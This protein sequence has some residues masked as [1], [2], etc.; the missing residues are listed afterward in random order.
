MN[1]SEPDLPTDADGGH[2]PLV[3]PRHATPLSEL[4]GDSPP[5]VRVRETIQ[6]LMSR[7]A[8]ARRLSPILLEGE[9]GTGKGLLAS[10][11]HRLT[12]RRDGPFVSINCAAIPETL[13]EAEL[14]G[15][16]RGAYTDA[17]Q[18]R[19]GLFQA[20]NGGTIF[21]D[22]VGLLS[23]ALQAKLLKV[24]EERAV[25]RLGSTRC[26]PVD[27]WVISASNEDLVVATRA[28]RFR[29]DL[30]H[31]LA[32]LTLR[33]PPLRERGVDICLLA[34]HFLRHLC[35]DYDMRPKTLTADA[36]AA[37]LAYRWPGNVRELSNVMERV[38]LLTDA[39]H[40]TAEMLALP[41]EVRFPSIAPVA[42]R[43]VAPVE[44]PASLEPTQM[45]DAL[46]ETGWNVSRTAA[47]LGMSRNALRY[48]IEKYRLRPGALPLPARPESCGVLA[49]SAPASPALG[50]P[51]RRP[52]DD[53]GWHPRR[54]AL[55]RA[56]LGSASPDA[57][58]QLDVLIEKVESFGGRIEE[59]DAAGIVGAFGL[60]PVEDAP[61]RAVL[62]AIAMQKA[63]E[64]EAERGTDFQLSIGV[65]IR[66]VPVRRMGGIPRIHPEARREAWAVL[67]ALVG[68]EPGR[69]L[70]E[71]A[72]GLGL[73]RDQDADWSLM[74]SIDALVS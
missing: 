65:H 57:S 2:R 39:P 13:L 31:R 46:E 34:E 18:S 17:R 64:R 54:V 56:V 8:E 33:L 30:Y 32:V 1:P 52:P 70:I 69:I 55:L 38:V 37:L 40:V 66:P 29:E 45:L 59:T 11:I 60:E 16:E 20:A 6:R 5:I 71:T 19:A 15:H 74:E 7:H 44:D 25:R 21:L 67:G 49:A 35:A 68:G 41:G 4:L 53:S 26:E 58:R 47:D 36:R 72:K 9:T 42:R 3:A 43:A 27:V 48:R 50:T 12:P 28:R 10:I 23:E 22:E 63:A 24:I 51:A 14:F 62:A 73:G 61:R